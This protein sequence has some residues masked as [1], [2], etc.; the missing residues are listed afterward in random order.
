MV[1]VVATASSG[2]VASPALARVGIQAPPTVPV[3]ECVPGVTVPLSGPS[4]GPSPVGACEPGGQQRFADSFVWLYLV[5]LLGLVGLIGVVGLVRSF[6]SG[7]GV[8][9]HSN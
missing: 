7:D 9:T 1:L 3:Q 4:N 6:R 2:P 5:L 8:I